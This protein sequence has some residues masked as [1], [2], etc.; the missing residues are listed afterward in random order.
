MV[1]KLATVCAVNK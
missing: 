1:D